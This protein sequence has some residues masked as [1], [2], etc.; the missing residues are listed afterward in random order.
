MAVEHAADVGL[1]DVGGNLHVAQIVGYQKQSGRLQAGGDG[2]AELD[3]ALDHHAVDRRADIGVLE[4]DLDLPH[5]GFAL[6]D[7]GGDG[8]ELRLGNAPVGGERVLLRLG[9]GQQGLRLRERGALGVA[10]GARGVERGL[11]GVAARLQFDLASQDSFGV[12]RERL[13][14][15]DLRHGVGLGRLGAHDLGARALDLRLGDQPLRANLLQI[16]A[17][18][19]EFGAD[20]V[21]I[22]PGDDL[23][24]LHFGIIIGENLDHL[25]GELGTHDH[26]GDRVDGTG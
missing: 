17:R 13:G 20:L 26:G 5:H 7:L 2:L 18:G 21:G 14:A 22:E 9:T 11:R 12:G 3:I 4:I 6:G 1:V 23:V 19:V 16:R 15:G 25:A 10:L 8:N 24:G